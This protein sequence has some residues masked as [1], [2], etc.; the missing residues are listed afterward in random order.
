MDSSVEMKNF[1]QYYGESLMDAWYR[2]KG[3]NK[4]GVNKHTLL[5]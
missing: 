2:M 4:N 5:L 1:G 3:I